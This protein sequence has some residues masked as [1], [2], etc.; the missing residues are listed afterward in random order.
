MKETMK[1]LGLH[2]L[3]FVIFHEVGHF[4]VTGIEMSFDSAKDTLSEKHGD[5]I[6]SVMVR[7]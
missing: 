2:S 5:I 6:F 4:R 1:F 7:L 3:I